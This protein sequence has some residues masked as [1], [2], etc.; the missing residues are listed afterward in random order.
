MLSIKKSQVAAK[1]ESVE[2]TAETLAAADAFLASNVNFKP[3]VKMHERQGVT[4]S[5][6]KAAGIPGLRSATM[7]FD[8]E[9]VGSSAAGTAPFWGKLMRACRSLETVVA[10]TSV[11]YTPGADNGPTLTMAWYEDGKIY[12]AWG[13]RGTWRIKANDGEPAMISWTFTFA[14]WE[15]VDGALLSGVSYD[16]TKP[17]VFM[18]AT[19]TI[20]SYAAAIA[21]MEIDAGNTVT[22]RKDVTASGGYSSA[23]VTD[24]KPTLKIDPE[25]ILAATKDFFAT[26]LAGTQVALSAAFGSAAGNTFAI[27]S[28]NVQYQEI[29]LSNRDSLG[30]TDINGLLCIDSG[31]D[32]WSIAIA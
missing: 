32:E 4:G 20:D 9:L 16:S 14:D 7:T 30:V 5:L 10:S 17:P 29:S 8:T 18:G 1:I 3:G 6:S 13:A 12:R 28:P 25:D 26:W 2:G 23:M 27:A 22:L 15:V 21:S 24:R 11:T 31:D 19:F